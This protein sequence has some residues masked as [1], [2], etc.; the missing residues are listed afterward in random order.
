MS[1]ILNKGPFLRRLARAT[2]SLVGMCLIVM[3][4]NA[5]LARDSSD[6]LPESGAP[7]EMITL[8]DG[9]VEL[10]SREVPIDQNSPPHSP[11][12]TSSLP[13]PHASESNQPKETVRSPVDV[14]PQPPHI[15]YEL[16]KTEPSAGA[17]ISLPEAEQV[18]VTGIIASEPKIAVNTLKD[19]SAASAGVKRPGE[20]SLP[21]DIWQRSTVTQA[22]TAM[23]PLRN[24]QVATFRESIIDV[25]LLQTAV[26]RLMPNSQVEEGDFLYARVRMLA[27]LQAY[28]AMRALLMAV[29]LAQRE[30]RWHGWMSW[31][32]V[33]DFK[34]DQACRLLQQLPG[35]IEDVV[36]QRRQLFCYG[37]EGAFDKAALLVELM[38][39]QGQ[40][41]PYWLQQ[42]L[43]GMG[44]KQLPLPDHPPAAM[45]VQDELDML[46][47]LAMQA[48]GD[49]VAHALYE[50]QPERWGRVHALHPRLPASVRLQA[51]EQAV[52][53][54]AMSGKELVELYQ[55]IDKK[56]LTLSAPSMSDTET[57]ISRAQ[58]YHEL[59]QLTLV[60]DVLE[61]LPHVIEQ[62]RR[63]ALM[64]VAVA[65]YGEEM[66]R[67]SRTI[68]RKP[69]HFALARDMI[70]ILLGAGYE[71]EAGLWLEAVTSASTYGMEG[72][73]KENWQVIMALLRA[74]PD[75][76]AMMQ[77]AGRL[78][79]PPDS[80]TP[81][82]QQALMRLATVLEALGVALKPD[83]RQ[84]IAQAEILPMEAYEAR[85]YDRP[86]ASDEIDQWG[87][88]L[89]EKR[90]GEALLYAAGWGQISLAARPDESVASLIR[91]LREA[92]L[93]HYAY[94]LAREVMLHWVYYG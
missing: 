58:R 40:E 76:D 31:H 25:A 35:K 60:Q 86:I 45:I 33:T 18:P 85:A 26:P 46:E 3:A 72:I 14:S 68:F 20:V 65:L 88:L 48:A 12:A 59:Q 13:Q 10:R 81:I 8:P 73:G 75:D 32:D 87:Q 92:E 42:L 21:A 61:R 82:Q 93:D 56:A 52:M 80:M 49:D 27:Q 29:P 24:L 51:A 38:R 79:S 55:S 2:S 50:H 9:G 36:W 94:Q 77:E 15:R 63:A 62:Y 1:F 91:Q 69:A 67:L 53:V 22:M 90:T 30:I 19:V 66:L 4:S 70:A 78:L 34:F 11:N 83:T 37:Q 84:H 43:A 64:P 39:E 47:I 23:N 5:T 16:E 71:D 7:L 54:G 74:T 44:N 57:P 89:R 28:D 6:T 41:V 17:S